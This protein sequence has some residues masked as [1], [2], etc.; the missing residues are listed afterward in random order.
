MNSKHPPIGFF[1]QKSI[2]STFLF[3][4]SKLNPDCKGDVKIK[5]PNKDSRVFLSDFLNRK[6]HR[7]SV[8]PNSIQMVGDSIYVLAKQKQDVCSEICMLESA[9]EIADDVQLE[10]E[11]IKARNS[12]LNFIYEMGWLLHRS[13]VKCRLDPTN[14]ELNLFPFKWFSWLMEFSVEHNWC[15][16]VKKLLGILFNGSVDS[17]EHPSVELA[18]LETYLLHRAVRRNCRCMV[19]FLMRYIPDGASKLLI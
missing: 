11:Q 18:L 2:P 6:M 17:A 14:P 12:A 1:G 5:D 10:S 4:S 9:I 13:Q 16:V 19:E 7:S 8:L 15:A 3:R